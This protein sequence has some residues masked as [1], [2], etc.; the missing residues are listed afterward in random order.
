M[1]P[2]AARLE[3]G[4]ALRALQQRIAARAG[5]VPAVR[6]AGALRGFIDEATPQM[7]RG[8]V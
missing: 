2:Y 1:A 8:W 4:F 6:E 3:D 7:V 5:V